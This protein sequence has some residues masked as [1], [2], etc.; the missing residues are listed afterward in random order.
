MFLF[1]VA[2]KM[3]VGE[4]GMFSS[5]VDYIKEL[6]TDTPGVL[7]FLWVFTIGSTIALIRSLGDGSRRSFGMLM[8]ACVFGGIG[9]VIADQIF[10]DT[11]YHIFVI[12]VAAVVTENIVLGLVKASGQFRDDPINIFTQL[13]KLIVPSIKDLR[14]SDDRNK[15]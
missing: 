5:L 10:V 13:W 12:G 8:F 3:G 11:K 9:A 15:K 1:A 14:V 4:R 7:N 6:V 2:A